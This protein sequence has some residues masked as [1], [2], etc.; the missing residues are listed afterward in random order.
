M[1]IINEKITL[2][3]QIQLKKVDMYEKAKYFGRTHP[4]VIKSSQ[5]LDNLLNQYQKIQ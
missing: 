5:E 2:I 3:E 1:V 4:V